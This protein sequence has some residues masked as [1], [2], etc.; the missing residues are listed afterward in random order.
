[1]KKVLSISLV[2]AAFVLSS[3][4]VLMGT[5]MQPIVLGDM[6]IYVRVSTAKAFIA[7]GMPEKLEID[8]PFDANGRFY[9]KN[10]VHDTTKGIA[11]VTLNDEELEMS[12]ILASY[13]KAAQNNPEVFQNDISDSLK[14]TRIFSAYDAL[15]KDC[16]NENLVD[17]DYN[18]EKKYT[19]RCYKITHDDGTPEDMCLASRLTKQGNI[20]LVIMRSFAFGTSVR[21]ELL[22]AI[23]S[24]EFKE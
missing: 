8:T 14:T 15:F 20:L 7:T 11:S 22:D 12:M 17:A 2:L 4:A 6:L 1:M 18:S 19:Y 9:Y 13:S 16:T 10:A 24:V 3:C 23:E 21:N 5:R